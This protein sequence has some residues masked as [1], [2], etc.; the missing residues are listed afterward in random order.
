MS[1]SRLNRFDKYIESKN[2]DHLKFL[3][4]LTFALVIIVFMLYSWLFYLSYM[5][6]ADPELIQLIIVD[7][8]FGL[9]YGG[10]AALVV[11][12]L[13]LLP[14][15]I[16]KEWDLHIIVPYALIRHLI[17]LFV[18]IIVLIFLP[19]T[20]Y[21]KNGIGIGYNIGGFLA[22]IAYAGEVKREHSR[23]MNK[24]DPDSNSTEEGE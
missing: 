6:L 15:Y 23:K 17:I 21:I 2:W 10:I 18:I 16:K 14:K 13:F 20:I 9:L 12:F 8:G 1:L 24:E 5:E 22:I 3:Q 4:Q 11:S 7:M 19:W